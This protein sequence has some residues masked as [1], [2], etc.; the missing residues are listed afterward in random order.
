MTIE[1]HL[2]GY[3]YTVSLMA[4][5]DGMNWQKNKQRSGDDAKQYEI[6]DHKETMPLQTKR[7]AEQPGS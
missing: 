1:S 7:L 3:I 4:L 6:N 2:T 5:V